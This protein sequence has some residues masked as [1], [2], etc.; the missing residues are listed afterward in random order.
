MK[1][2][3]LVAVGVAVLAGSAC[4]KAP[5]CTAE[6]ASKKAQDMAAALQEAVTKD[7]SKAA[8][9]TA[10]VQEV[11]TKYQ[12]TATLADACKAFDEVTAAIKG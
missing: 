11:T 1:K 7:P 6:V 9:L 12:G 5:E 3:L 4:S 10:K 8:D 2:F